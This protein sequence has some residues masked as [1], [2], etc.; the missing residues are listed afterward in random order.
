MASIKT[1]SVAEY[2]RAKGHPLSYVYAM[3]WSGKLQAK[4][5]GRVW[6]I[7]ASAVEGRITEPHH[8][9]REHGG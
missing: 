9:Q 6:R 7:P 4:K 1:M 2:A 5:V 8:P 3:V